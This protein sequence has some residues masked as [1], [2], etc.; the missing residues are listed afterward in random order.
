MIYH[1]LL[2]STIRWEHW[3]SIYFTCWIE[4]IRQFI[5][6]LHTFSVLQLKI[7]AINIAIS[8]LMEISTVCFLLL[9]TL[10]ALLQALFY[11]CYSLPSQNI[12]ILWKTAFVSLCGSQNLHRAYLQSS[13]LHQDNSAPINRKVVNC[14]NKLWIYNPSLS[15]AYFHYNRS[16]YKGPGFTVNPMLF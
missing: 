13:I 5:F 12:S 8:L 7:D 1:L 4:G 16:N 2:Y 6:L 9:Q 11:S 10:F 3:E 14:Q 15:P